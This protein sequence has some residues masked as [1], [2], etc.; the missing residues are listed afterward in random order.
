MQMCPTATWKMKHTMLSYVDG[1]PV[2]QKTEHK[3]FVLYVNKLIMCAE[4]R[5]KV[6]L[7]ENLSLKARE[8]SVIK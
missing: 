4:L 5:L 6:M 3:C 7:S 8:I 2:T 1:K